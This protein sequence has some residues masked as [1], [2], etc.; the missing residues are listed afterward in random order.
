MGA[1]APLQPVPDAPPGPKQFPKADPS[2]IR[3]AFES[4]RYPCGRPMGTA[5]YE[6]GKAR[7]QAELLKVQIWAQET[8]QVLGAKAGR[9]L[10]TATPP[11]LRKG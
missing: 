7:L 10:E 8:G 11:A 6:T 1:T 5:A 3:L 2:A 4:G 9:I